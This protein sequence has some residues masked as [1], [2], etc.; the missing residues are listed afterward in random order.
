MNILH[1][2]NAFLGTKVHR[3][4]AIHLDSLGIQQHIFTILRSYKAPNIDNI[5]DFKTDGSTI[6]FSRLLKLYHRL[7]FFIKSKHIY[8]DLISQIDVTNIQLSH[9]TT[10]FTDGYLAYKLKQQYNIPYIVTIRSTDVDYFFKFRPDLLSTGVKI[11]N[12]ANSIVFVSPSLRNRFLNHKI[13]KKLNKEFVGKISTFN[14]GVDSF[15]LNNK[16]V[17]K[18]N[19]TSPKLLFVGRLV[20]RKNLV[21]LLEAINTLKS[22]YPEI[23]LSIVGSNGDYK[24]KILSII[25]K[26]YRDFVSIYPPITD[27]TELR[28][29]YNSHDVFAMPAYN[30]TFGLVYIEALTQGLPIIYTKNDGVDGIFD[31]FFIGDSVNPKDVNSIISAIKKVLSDYDSLEIK[32][33]DFKKFDWA[34][35]AKQYHELYL[36]LLKAI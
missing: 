6:V 35:I 32:S 34:I 14:N 27:K 5:V 23:K 10:L 33:I 29:M 30:E 9:A 3:N 16:G 11:L 2:S 36:S 31:D 22:I 8:K 18:D 7:F 28:K 4:L 26:K 13:V 15:W 24:E 25:D 12:E 1:I 19:W 20:K 17:Q 21:R